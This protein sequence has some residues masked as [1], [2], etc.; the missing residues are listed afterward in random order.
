[1]RIQIGNLTICN[2]GRVRR[3]LQEAKANG[4]DKENPMLYGYV[5][6]CADSHWFGICLYRNS[7][8]NK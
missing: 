5:V 2:V 1:M 4:W 8:F 6:G 3:K 7:L